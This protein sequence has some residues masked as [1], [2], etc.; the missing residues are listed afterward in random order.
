[1][2]SVFGAASLPMIACIALLAAVIFEIL[3]FATTSW[4]N[5]GTH[6]VGLWRYGKCYRPAHYDCVKYDHVEYFASGTV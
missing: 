4:S 3:G 6:D 5:D 2:P 1:M